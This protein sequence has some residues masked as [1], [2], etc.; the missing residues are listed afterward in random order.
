MTT[1][2]KIYVSND[3][4]IT[5]VGL[6]DYVA[7][8]YINDSTVTV[9]VVDSSGT[10]ISGETWPLSLPYVTAS[11]GNYQGTLSDVLVLTADDSY[12]AQITADSG[13]GKKGYWEAPLI[14]TTRTA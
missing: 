5:L 8:T 12:T 10:S 2:L 9:T 3:N 14:G 1:A 13:G 4:I 7:D 6:K 11:N